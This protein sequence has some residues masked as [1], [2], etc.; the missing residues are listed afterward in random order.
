MGSM[1]RGLPYR[2]VKAIVNYQY[3]VAN[4]IGIQTQRNQAYFPDNQKRRVEVLQNWLA[5]A[6]NRGCSINVANSTMAGRIIFVYAGNM[7]VAQGMC[8]L[9]D[10]AES[11]RSRT[12]LVFLFVGR[13][14]DAQHLRTDADKRGLNN[15]AFF[16]EIDPTEILGLY[17]QCHIGLIALDPRH[18]THNIPG[19][20]YLTCKL[21]CL[22][23]PAS[24]LAMIW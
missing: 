24:T 4:V 19:K 7:G 2:F 18:K 5:D 22:S 17:A 9:L 23:W 3:F 1:S 13:G 14:S 11:L 12:D 20:F 21:A 10:L 15:V 8:I 16:D 6:P